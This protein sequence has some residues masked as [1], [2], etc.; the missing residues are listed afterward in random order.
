MFVIHLL[1]TGRLRSE[2]SL[3]ERCV[4]HMKPRVSRV[5]RGDKRGADRELMTHCPHVAPAAIITHGKWKSQNILMSVSTS[6][7]QCVCKK[8]SRS[9]YQKKNIFVPL[10]PLRY[11]LQLKQHQYKVNPIYILFYTAAANYWA[12]NTKY[13]KTARKIKICTFSCFNDFIF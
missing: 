1:L 9:L 7:I 6:F 11:A 13:H 5:V 4:G 3:Q 8:C 10:L 12:A 2:D